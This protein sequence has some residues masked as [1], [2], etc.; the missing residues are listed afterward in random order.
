MLLAMAIGV[1][2]V[3]VFISLGDS[4]RRYVIDQFSSLGTNLLIVLPGRSETTGGPP[5]L[6]GETPR[7]LTLDDAMALKRARTVGRIAPIIAGSAPISVQGLEREMLVLG[8]TAELF[9]IRHLTL[10]Q[11][12]FLPPGDPSRA[13]AVCVIGLEGKKE[14]FASRP[15]IGKWLRIGDRR[16]RVIGIL[17]SP[18]VSLGED[19]GEIVIVPVAAAQSLFN[20]SSLFRILVEAT[21][22]AGIEQTRQSILDII[23]IRHEGE[24]DIT[25]ITQ[26]AVLTTF[27][28]IF[29]ALTL[30]VTGIAAIS[31]IVAGIMIMNVM[32]VAVSN[33]RAEIG[34]LKALGAS[35]AQIMGLF[36]TESTILSSIGAAAGLILAL[37]GLRL[38]GYL[39]PEF[40]LH[41]AS[42]SPLIAIAV[43]LITGIVFGVMPA[44]RAATLEPALALARR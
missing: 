3:V 21:S 5:P 34:L 13:E 26:D 12:T 37:F 4:A 7:D 27:D 32:L 1:G 24:D 17:S 29:K 10:S 33:R 39:F 20:A 25:V 15:A 38:A 9:E 19:L 40:P 30:S 6:L 28:R 42:W 35:R 14:L 31:L 2:S 18:G 41:L 43:A 8:S 44:R 23:R 11:G 22:P 36:L 16:F